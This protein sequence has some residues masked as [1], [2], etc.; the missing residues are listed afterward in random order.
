MVR[1]IFVC[2]ALLGLVLVFRPAAAQPVAH[3][4]AEQILTGKDWETGTFTDVVPTT[5]GLQPSKVVATYTTAPTTAPRPFTHLLLRWNVTLPVSAT[6]AWQGRVSSDGQRW[7]DWVV[8][9]ENHD[10]MDKNDADG[11]RYAGPSYAGVARWWQ[12]RATFTTAPNGEQPLLHLL[13]VNTVDG[14]N[15]VLGQS[16]PDAPRQE[17]TNAVSRPPFVSRSAWGGSEVEANSVPTDYY[18]ANH[19][20]VHHTAD[21][22]NFVGSEDSWADRVRAIWAFHTYSTNG[23]RGWGDI[24]Y[25]WIVDP[26]GVIYEGRRGSSENDRDAVAFHDTANSGSVGVVMIGTFANVAPSTNQQ[27][28]LVNILAWKADQRDIDPWG[29]SYY[30]GCSRSRY[31]GPFNPSAVVANLAGHREVTPGH[32]TCPGNTAFDLLPSLRQRVAAL[33]Q[34]SDNGDLV[35]DDGEIGFNRLAGSWYTAAIGFQNRA[36]YTYGTA[37]SAENRARWTPTLPLTGQ[38]QVEVFVPSATGIT[39][40]P[41]DNARYRIATAQGERVRAVSQATTSGWVDIG[42]HQFNAGTG[43]NVVL[44]DVT[45]EPYSSANRRPIF[46]DAVRWTYVPP[47]LPELTVTAAEFLPTSDQVRDGVIQVEAGGVMR[48]RF[49]VENT[50][51]VP[52]VSQAPASGSVN[53]LTSGYVYDENECFLGNLARSYPVFGGETGHVRVAL[54]ATEG[55]TPLGLDCNGDAQ[56]YPWRW[57]VGNLAPGAQRTIVG[58]VRMQNYGLNYRTIR[59]SAGAVNENVAV[60]A[61]DISVGLLNVLPEARPPRMSQIN[62]AGQPLAQVWT[63]RLTPQSLLERT[64]NPLSVIEDRLVGTLPWDGSALN[65]GLTG[66]LSQTDQ[67]VL[68]QVRPIEVPETGLYRFRL[69]TDDGAWLW[70]DGVLVL[71]THGLYDDTAAVAEQFL[72]AGPHVLAIKY[73][74][75]TGPARA[76]YRWQPPGS[77]AWQTIPVMPTAGSVDGRVVVGSAQLRLAAD[78]LGGAGIEMLSYWLDKG[79]EQVTPRGLQLV[80]IADATEGAHS[81]RYRAYDQVYNRSNDYSVDF[82][83]NITAPQTTLTTTL[84]TKGVIRLDWTSSPDARQFVVEVENM[85]AGGWRAWHTTTLTQTLFFGTP[86][87]SYH[88]RIT[89]T[90]G[91]YT[92]RTDASLPLIVPPSAIFHLGHLPFVRR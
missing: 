54:T 3:R 27:T 20:V 59:F 82:Y 83:A 4:P 14:R 29:R 26:N 70:I 49:T 69:D 79:Y 48:V 44:D 87:D 30:Y 15:V 47:S 22:N 71:D 75:Y 81:L 40:R 1:R 62:A 51:S 84:S 42:T 7:T 52:I 74:E 86:G 60:L 11:T 68:T 50:G 58:A 80:T 19:L 64:A 38:Y 57:D 9:D 46:F 55:G 65:W 24:G 89:T 25:N 37:G 63:L 35:I 78:D 39:G 72:T 31:C 33:L 61:R 2:L 56:G 23:G 43:G 13:A 92:A 36:L 45:G 6:V 67:F 91:L 17:T 41:T 16:A 21:P 53:D 85:G 90:D 76:E 12:L 8:L 32:T 88:F 28:A 10:L 5:D 18:P 66:P 34:P 77:S 73:F